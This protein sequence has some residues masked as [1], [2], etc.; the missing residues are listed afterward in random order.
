MG[1][2]ESRIEEQE[3]FVNEKIKF[4]KSNYPNEWDDLIKTQGM[5]RITGKIRSIYN[6]T[7]DDK[8]YFNH[9]NYK[10]F[11]TLFSK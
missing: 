11:N 8:I 5:K 3:K 6:N 7:L 10:C 1:I 2:N 4:I 9:T